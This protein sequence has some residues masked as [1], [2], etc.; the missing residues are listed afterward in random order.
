MNEA[1]SFYLSRIGMGKE[2]TVE[3]IIEWF[4]V[5]VNP[6]K[7]TNQVKRSEINW[8]KQGEN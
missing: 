5:N 1:D 7:I 8:R 4:Q 3:H 6:V 2:K